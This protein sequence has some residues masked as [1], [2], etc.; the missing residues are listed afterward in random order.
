MIPSRFPDGA[1][2]ACFGPN[3][4]EEVAVCET[5]CRKLGIEY[6]AIDLSAEY[7][8]RVLN[9]FRR[10]YLGGR[11]PNPCIRCNNEIKFGFLIE[12]AH[13]LG[14]DFD[15]F[16]TGHYARISSAASGM[17]RLRAALDQSKDQSYFLYRLG[18]QRLSR[19]LFPLGELTK[20]QVRDKA[21]KLGLE[22]AEKPESQ[23]FIAGGDYSTLFAAEAPES[24]DIVDAD[25]RI[26]GRHR[27]LPYYTIG[28]RRGLGLGAWIAAGGGDPEPL[29]VIALD[30]AKNRVVVGGNW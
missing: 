22:V 5:L 15:Y 1:S 10:E 11:T 25:G 4:E 8:E 14:L 23:D 18:P 3:E 24:G 21:R 13:A 26:L 20:G 28:Q 16:A 27:G 12:R 9:Y 6:R 29:Y 30:P 19:V 7:E 17:V 2:K